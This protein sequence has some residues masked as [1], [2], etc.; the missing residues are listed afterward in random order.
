M[1]LQLKSYYKMCK[2]HGNDKGCDS[3]MDAMCDLL[4]QSGVLP[5]PITQTTENDKLTHGE[6]EAV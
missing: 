2:H 5:F 4:S 3:A 6:Q 1:M